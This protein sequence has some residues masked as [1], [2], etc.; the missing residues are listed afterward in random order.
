[1]VLGLCRSLVKD[2][3]DAEDAFQATFLVLVR[4]ADSIRRR[5]TIAPWLHGVAARVAR[6]AFSRLMRRRAREVPVGAEIPS[7]ERASHE[8]PSTEDI[9]HEEIARLPESIRAPV[10]LCCLEGLSY[11]LAA[12]RLGVT[13]PTL[14]GRLHRA[15]KRLAARLRGR[16]LD[17]SLVAI[18]IEPARFCLPAPT[19]ALVRETVEMSSRWA[20]VAGLATG[21]SAVPDSI[22]NLAQGVIK[23]MFVQSYKLVG[24][25]AL[26]TASALGT[27]VLGQQ[28]KE[29]SGEPTAPPAQAATLAAQAKMDPREAAERALFL[30]QRTQMILLKLNQVIDAEFPNGTTIE[31]ILKH[32]KQKTTD[33]HFPGIPIYVAPG[34]LVETR[35]DL[36]AQIS[37]NFKEQPVRVILDQALL[38]S[39]L[40]YFVKDGFLQIDSRTGILEMRV[41]EIDRKLDRVLEALARLERAK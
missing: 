25:A 20:S 18:A 41:E 28:G 14:R 16:G 24:M 38:K 9:V 10:V 2:P 39:G 31:G 5:D 15:R 8:M 22:T 6:R 34:A 40:S 1:M 23:I 30:A 7:R 35:Q 4:K 3:H 26:V 11:D 36:T 29:G 12:R 27:A 17:S 13:E 33:G 32:I 19:T 21:A 37:M